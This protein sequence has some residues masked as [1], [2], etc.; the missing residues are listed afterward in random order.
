MI[1]ISGP[2]AIEVYRRI[3]RGKTVLEGGSPQVQK[4]KRCTIMDPVSGEELDD[5]LVVYFKG[6]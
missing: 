4:M 2:E 1:R 3:V 5:G 6:E